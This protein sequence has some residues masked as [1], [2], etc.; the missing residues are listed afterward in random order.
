M[1]REIHV[2]VVDDE[3]AIRSSLRGNLMR[4]GIEVTGEESPEVVNKNTASEEKEET[5]EAE[6]EV[7][8]NA[9]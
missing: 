9:E 5:P 4:F 1:E 3:E 6:S 2:L 8:E 7:T